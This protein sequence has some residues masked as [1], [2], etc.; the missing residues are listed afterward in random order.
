MLTALNQSIRQIDL[1]RWVI[2]SLICERLRGTSP[3]DA[4][5]AWAV[6]D[7]TYILR[8]ARGN[9][10]DSMPYAEPSDEVQLVHEGGTSSAV[11]VI[12]SHA[13]CKVKAWNPEME[14]EGNTID[15]VK[16]VAP[17]MSTPE[18]IYT[19]AEQDRSFL[20][21]SRVKGSTLRD[22]WTSLSPVQRR[23][24]LT[25][26]ADYCDCLAQHR[27]QTLTS[28][29]GKP[30]LEPFL[31]SLESGLLGAL[32]EKECLEYFSSPSAGSPPL[33][34]GFR[35]YH[36]DLGPG[37]VIMSDGVVAGVIDWEAASYYPVS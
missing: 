10:I 27:S 18:V 34:G 23:S 6:D 22:A 21:L 15:F 36:P 28:V 20:I 4:V 19:W 7:T 9:E 2:G 32:T 37:N 30:V 5:T 16:R 8:E 24:A 35:F 29:T 1:R 25:T 14:S 33:E 13:F 11:W 31:S 17:Q 3:A 12:G 26:V